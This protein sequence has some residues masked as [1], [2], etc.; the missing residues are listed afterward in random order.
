MTHKQ[1]PKLAVL[2]ALILVFSLSAPALA[3][4]TAVAE[5]VH[6]V[7]NLVDPATVELAITQEMAIEKAVAT[8][9]I[10]DD[11]GKPNIN[12]WSDS[13][14]YGQGPTWNL[15][16]ESDP[17][18]GGTRVS[19]S[20]GIHAQSGEIVSYS[21]YQYDPSGKQPTV[22]LTR[23]EAQKNAED[24]YTKL[25]SGDKKAEPQ[26]NQPYAS[27]DLS[28]TW[29]RLENGIP[30]PDNTIN[31]TIN[32][33][34]GTLSNFYRSWD[35]KLTF[36]KAEGVVA[37]ADAQA[38]HDKVGGAELV[39]QRFYTPAG[40]S[41][42][43]LAYVNKAQNAYVNALTGQVVDYNGQPWTG[44][45][46]PIDLGKSDVELMKLEKPMTREQALALARQYLGED[47][48]VEPSYASYSAPGQPAGKF[49][50]DGLRV[51]TWNFSWDIQG[52]E[53]NQSRY[54]S[55]TVDL[56]HGVLMGFNCY[57]G[58]VTDEQ[59]RERTSI[60]E[61]AARNTAIGF[62]KKIRP[63]LINH[64]SV[65]DRSV[66]EQ[67][68][69]WPEGRPAPIQREY[70]FNFHRIV[71]GLRFDGDSL[72]VSVDRFSGQVRNLYVNWTDTEFPKPE[73]AKLTTMGA[74]AAFLIESPLKL[75]YSRSYAPYSDGEQQ[76]HL[77]YR[78]YNAYGGSLID[79]VTGHLLDY[80]GRDLT[81]LTRGAEDIAE[82]PA[83][84]EIQLMINRGVF[85]VK[86][87][88][89]GP[90]A[91]MTRGDVAKAL[92][93]AFNQGYMVPQFARMAAGGMGGAAP[94][95]SYADVSYDNGYFGYVEAAVRAGILMP[96]IAS[97]K[98]NP[99]ELVTNEELALLTARAMGYATVISMKN[100]I[101]NG[102]TDAV[103]IGADYGNAVGLLAGLE[104][105]TNQGEFKP[106]DH[107]TRADVAK[108]L[109]LAT[110]KAQGR[111]YY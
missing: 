30:F 15:N 86:D 3:A 85:G 5:P 45:G 62:L 9:K 70:Y 24:W 72:S 16:W 66:L 61:E 106:Q 99:D 1:N 21:A 100:T 101:S 65:T 57:D 44:V 25:M 35:D 63:D 20:V 49:A 80:S 109:A 8:F 22:N 53:A 29:I 11:L 96:K 19:Y 110:Q 59:L 77:V 32:P 7:V 107:V 111:Y 103:K 74:M 54:L 33:S 42:I 105:L 76:V 58:Y 97:E 12:L 55:T 40:R 71:N 91:T 6:S 41:E 79:P 83:K 104:V 92:V 39:Y 23:D 28:F 68:P 43:R 81:E 17:R 108:V 37:A 89:F 102:F 48:K 98:L 69:S 26:S 14:K 93:I 88:K 47:A 94:A 51:S 36:P 56:D 73:E 75:T 13:G 2:V 31:I 46:N 52:K 38:A 10:P 90:D 95:P 82:H 67:Y 18:L 64:L 87:G 4:P 60:S 78:P 27:N 84:R 34:D 50:D